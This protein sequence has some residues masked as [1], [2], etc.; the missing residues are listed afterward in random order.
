MIKFRKSQT[1]ARPK[2]SERK[3]AGRLGVRRSAGRPMSKASVGGDKLIDAMIALLRTNEVA[4]ITTQ[5]VAHRAGV[6]PALIRYYF[7]D[8]TG[9]LIA[10]TGR[11]ANALQEQSAV[12]LR[13]TGTA[14]ARLRRRAQTLV[15]VMEEHPRFHGLLV[16]NV[17]ASKEPTADVL[18][19]TISKQGLSLTADFVAH[20]VSTG[21]LRRV[22]PRF[23]HLMLI[24]ICEFFVTSRPLRKILFRGAPMK[25]NQSQAFVDFVAN[26]LIHGLRARD[27]DGST[28]S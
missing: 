8:L 20:G 27:S 16:D 11:I 7:G 22:D 14:E 21:Q 6:D 9:L 3:S 25:G 15:D 28:E 24:G 17:F 10:V 19:E 23:L 2:S 26:V 13:S 18:L 12:V 5:D 4:A 1:S